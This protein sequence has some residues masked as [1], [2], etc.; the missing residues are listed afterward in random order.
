MDKLTEK[1]REYAL[2]IGADEIGFSNIERFSEAPP[3]YQPLALLPTAK[4]I[5]CMSIRILKGVQIP[6]KNLVQNYQYQM[7]GYGWLSNIRLNNLGFEV[8]RYIEDEGFTSLPF[9]SFCDSQNPELQPEWAR[10]VKPVIS[11]RHAAV[12]C[13]I[14]TF[15]WNNLALTKKYGSRNRFVT[16]ITNAK[17]EPTPMIEEEYCKNCGMCVKKCPGKAIAKEASVSFNIGGKKIKIAEL[18]RPT[19]SWYH[20]GMATETFGT[21]PFVRSKEPTWDEVYAKRRAVDML[22]PNQFGGRIIAFTT[23]G[24]CGQ[25][26]LQCPV[27]TKWKTI[28]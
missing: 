22:S 13:G 4:S 26:L 11:N 14:A 25:C 9:P 8:A 18:K 1:I 20:D 23:G 17:L 24:H 19:C 21:V 10:R 16:I 27:G 2:K 5:I 28:K 6:Q 7:F 3:Q 12:A 15:G